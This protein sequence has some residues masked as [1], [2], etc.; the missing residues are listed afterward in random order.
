[1]RPR[2]YTVPLV[3][4][5]TTLFVLV[6][7]IV[8]VVAARVGSGAAAPCIVGTWKVVRH[9]ETVPLDFAPGSVTIVGGEGATL[10]LRADGTGESDYGTGTEYLGAVG[11]QAVRLVVSGRVTF[12]YTTEGGSARLTDIDVQAKAQAFVD[13]EAAGAAEDLE[14]IGT[15]TYTCSGDALTEVSGAARITYERAD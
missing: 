6:A 10:S 15:A 5:G 2:S 7:A 12:D 3:A 8:V 11:A 9:E 14:P 4:L 1:M 13:G